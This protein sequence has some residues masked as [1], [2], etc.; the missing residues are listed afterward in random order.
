VFVFLISNGRSGSS[1]IHEVLSRHPE[2]GFVSNMEDRLAWLPAGAG[3]RNNDIYRRVP[4]ALTVK[5]R[6]RFAPSEAWRVLAR[7]VSP[8]LVKSSRDL[9]ATDAM[10]W[11]AERFRSFFEDRAASQRKPVFLH[12]FTGWPRSGFIRAVFPDARFIHIVR[13]GR[14][15]V[16]SDLRVSWWSGWL[17]PPHVGTWPLPAPYAAEWEASGQSFPVLAGISW[18]TMMDAFAAARELVPEEQ[19]LDVRFED[20]LTDPQASFKQMLDFADLQP[21]SRFDTALSNTTFLPGRP[22]AF[23]KD[24]DPRTLELLEACLDRHLREWGYV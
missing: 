7:E 15:V 21:S 20:V 3:R 14:A 4:Q 24:L 13:D 2:I 11:V 9:L 8:M 19:W 12:K 10:P 6:P 23:R 16:A 5:G 17:G 1:L 18:K 22:D